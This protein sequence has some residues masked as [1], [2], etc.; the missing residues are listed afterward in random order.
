[1]SKHFETTRIPTSITNIRKFYTTGKYSIYQN[2]PTPKIF[3]LNK[4]TYVSISDTLDYSLAIGI[5][6]DLY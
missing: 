3:Q 1:M 5:K 4:H 6:I 2:L